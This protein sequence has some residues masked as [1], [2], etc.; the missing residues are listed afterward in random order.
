M[1]AA[2]LRRGFSR[3][4]F[5]LGLSAA[6]APAFAQDDVTVLP[7]IVITPDRT[8]MFADRIGS[9]VSVVERKEIE[10][11]NP[12]SLADVLRTVPAVTVTET[13]GLGSRTLV[14][15]RG[16]EAQHTLVL[17][18][19]IRANDPASARDEFDFATTAAGD[20]ERIEILRGPQSAVYGADAMGG[21]I[22]IITRRPDGES[23]FV[24]TTE[25]GSYG[26]IGSTASAGG[27]VGRF[28]LTGS[29]TGF[30]TE[31]FSRVGDRDRDEADA[32]ARLAGSFRGSVD[33]GEARTVDF[34]IAV[35][36][37]D[38]EFDKTPTTRWTGGPGNAPDTADRTL[39]TAHAR[40]RG[41]AWDGR[42]VNTLTA[43]AAFNERRFDEARAAA[44]AV[45]TYFRGQSFGAEAQTELDLESAGDLLLGLRI[46]EETAFQQRTDQ[47]RPAFDAA[48]TLYAV[49]ALHGIDV[50]DRL[51]LSFA[52]RWDGDLAGDG[53]LTG[54][55]AA[56]Y[57]I[58]ETGTI[59]RTSAGNGAKRPTAFQL[60]FNPALDNERSVGADAGI[61]QTILDGRAT[62]T[63]T[64]FY[65]RFNGLIDFT[66]DI[67]T[68]TYRNIDAAQTAGF[69]AMAT[70]E[71]LPG[72]LTA[73]GGYTWLRARDLATG[74]A[75]PRRAEHSGSA[76]L[77]FTGI[78]K[79]STTLSAT[80][81]GS[82]F[83]DDRA[84]IRLAP[85]A[86]LDFHVAYQATPSLR[87]FGRVE[88]ILNSRY[89]E[90]VGYNT[91]GR[92]AY[93]GLR[94]QH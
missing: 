74:L 7:V 37:I 3:A 13:G 28:N 45:T 86:R 36:R 88:N 73:S 48:R 78:D 22:N 60:S 51:R 63:V 91:A 26:T 33:L 1:F 57:R 66:G 44:P 46:E 81:V 52:G 30:R 20:I 55:F 2:S 39:A 71:L 11:R 17:I 29:V 82:R 10:L 4:A 54:R 72:V 47:V 15:I 40:F 49:N 14:G 90:I 16:A 12:G 43:F 64:G 79:L 6:A 32:T 92:A 58:D 75:L 68:G 56:A 21:V 65:N 94:W 59:L 85:Y 77:T 27:S 53:F 50:G 18:D 61:E 80:L 41:E 8:A 23:R 38:A 25:A 69:E 62:L 19:G 84:T 24:V 5:L 9:T 42:M 93:A 35:H 76:A 83:D 70:A 31:G 89:Q 34:G 87:I 67:V